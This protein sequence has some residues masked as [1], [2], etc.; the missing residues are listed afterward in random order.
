M[1]IGILH[2]NTPILFWHVR[3]RMDKD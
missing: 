1:T 3:S 2:C